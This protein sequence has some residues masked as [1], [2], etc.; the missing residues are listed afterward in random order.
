MNKLSSFGVSAQLS[1][2]KFIDIAS[3]HTSDSI[4]VLRVALYRELLALDA[5]PEYLKGIPLVSRRDSALRPLSKILSED[6]WI[7]CNLHF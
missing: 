4:N 6:C 7:I 5:V 1:K 3:A 2:L